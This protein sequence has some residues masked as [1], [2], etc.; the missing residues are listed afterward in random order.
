MIHKCSLAVFAPLL[1]AVSSFAQTTQPAAILFGETAVYKAYDLKTLEPAVS[2]EEWTKYDGTLS[3]RADEV[4][5]DLALT[6]ASK[7]EHVKTSVIDYYKFVRGWHDQHDAKTR[8]LERDAKANDSKIEDERKDLT[9]G[10][11]AFLADLSSILTPAEVE[12]VKDRLCYRRPTIM[13]DGFTQQ[14]PWLTA[15]QKADI[16]KICDDARDTA[17]DGGSSTEKHHIMDKYKGRLTNYIARAKKAAA[18]R[19]AE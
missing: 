14:N 8:E 15:E 16:K 10:H 4:L 18:T 11:E 13:Y 7:A 6:D 17:M 2:A 3:G 12:A 5:K 1:I 19:P 9:A